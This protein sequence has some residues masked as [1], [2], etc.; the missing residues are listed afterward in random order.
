M[1]TNF[2]VAKL[3][4]LINLWLCYDFDEHM[5]GVAGVSD[6]SQL[7]LITSL[8]TLQRRCLCTSKWRNSRYHLH[9]HRHRCLLS[10]CQ[11][12][13][14]GNGIYGTDCW[15]VSNAVM[16]LSLFYKADFSQEGNITGF[17]NLHLD[18]LKKRSL[19][20]SVGFVLWVGKAVAPLAVSLLLL[21]F[22]VLLSSIM[23]TMFMSDGTARCSPSPWYFL[24]VF[25]TPSWLDTCLL[26]KVLYC[27]YT[28]VASSQSLSHCGCLDL[29]ATHTKS[30]LNSR[31]WAAGVLVS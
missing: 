16:F 21:K 3:W 7:S 17:P 30:G 9:V 5:A 1:L 31:I 29:E 15:Y 6:I 2:R 20:S 4:L 25:S 19:T 27:V 28:L 26:W 12:F 18:R 10:L 23:T 8:I 22:R 24:F 11:R 14:G 13:Y